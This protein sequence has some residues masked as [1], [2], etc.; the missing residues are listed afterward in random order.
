LLHAPRQQAFPQI[1]EFSHLAMLDRVSACFFQLDNLWRKSIFEGAAFDT[2]TLLPKHLDTF[3]AGVAS[4][5]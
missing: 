3:I 1:L 2:H 5:C 4:V